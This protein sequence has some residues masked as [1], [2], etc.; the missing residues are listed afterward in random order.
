[1]K[2]TWNEERCCGSGQCV[3]AAPDLFDQREEDGLAVLLH[4]YPEAEQHASAREAA[5]LCPG[6]AISIEGSP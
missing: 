6:R 1:M 5:L 4:P 3:L 2:I